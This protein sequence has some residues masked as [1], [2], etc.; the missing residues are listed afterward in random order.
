MA[1]IR[2]LAWGDYCCSTG[3]GTVLSNIMRELEASGKY[4][5]DVVGINYDG[6]PYDTERFPGKVYPALSGIR[7]Q[8]AYGDVFGRQVVLD[9][10]SNNEYDVFFALQDT[11]IVQGF[12][13][14]LKDALKNNPANTKMVYYFPIDASPK[15]DWIEDVVNVIDYPVAYTNY[16]REECAKFNPEL[17]DMRVIYHGT[18]L[19]DFYPIKDYAVNKTFKE[20]YFNYQAD[21]KFLVT[22]VNRNQ[23]RKD[24]ARNFAIMRELKNRGQ[25]DI[26]F[27]L[28]MSHNDVGGNLLVMADNYGLKQGTDYIFPNPSIFS[29]D[30]GLPIEILNGIY[31]VSDAVIT[32]TLGEGWGLSITEALATK[33]PMIGPDNTSLHEILANNRGILVP[34]GNNPSM[35]ITKESDNE[36]IRPLMD[37]QLAAQAIIDLKTKKKVPDVESAYKWVQALNWYDITKQ[38]MQVI[39]E[40][41]DEAINPKL[42]RQQKRALER[43][44]IKNGNL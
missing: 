35:W 28:H 44:K 42:S 33:T 43:E 27:Y 37:V 12:I 9:L 41:A 14:Q 15:K 24:I 21:N 10:L 11:F 8:G 7:M 25:D 36:R 1:K 19:K 5:I 40:A 29:P 39:D 38:W 13:P 30:K 2:L 31:N 17:K 23:S 32:T 16:A 20:S 18:N 26:L 3:F 4:E 34:S 6:G 22:N